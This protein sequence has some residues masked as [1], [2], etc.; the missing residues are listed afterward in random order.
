MQ[1]PLGSWRPWLLSSLVTGSKGRG[2][3]P[4]A[5]HPSALLSAL[6]SATSVLLLLLRLS[7]LSWRNFLFLR[8]QV[9]EVASKDDGGE[10]CCEVHN[11]HR[12]CGVP[13]RSAC[14]GPRSTSCS[15]CHGAF[16]LFDSVLEY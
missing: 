4:Q 8:I 10:R 13:S 7:N 16:D 12:A 9:I 15:A 1:R 6:P 14:L 5:S 3:P 2:A 11:R